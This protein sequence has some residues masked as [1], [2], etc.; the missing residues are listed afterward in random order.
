MNIGLYDADMQ[1]YIHVPF[2]LELM[3]ISSYYKR[4]NHLVTFMHNLRP[5]LYGSV[6]YFK[7]Y[8]DGI[9][10]AEVT[11]SNVVPVGLSFTSNKYQP[12]LTDIELS[13]PDVFIYEGLRGKFST[14]PFY[15]SKFTTLT[16]AVHAR[17]SLDGK[18]IW[19]DWTKPFFSA[20]NQYLSLFI[21]DFDV[22]S[23]ERAPE[24]IAMGLDYLRDTYPNQ[25]I[26][27]VGT[28]FPICV[29]NDEQFLKWIAFDTLNE[30]FPL[31][32]RGIMQ[33]S[34]FHQFVQA[35]VRTNTSAQFVKNF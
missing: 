2:N 17:L 1:T 28:K 19:K 34:T 7:D 13:T 5:D 16:N 20:N 22:G 18:T 33:D 29:N 27:R 30:F 14:D 6:F 26:H 15:A 9:Y 32:Y 10:P 25:R 31:E 8:F 11:D 35:K 12:Q 21:H 3:K 23:L 4:H 24:T